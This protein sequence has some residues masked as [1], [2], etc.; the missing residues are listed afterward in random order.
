MTVAKNQESCSKSAEEKI[1]K[2]CV[3]EQNADT[4]IVNVSG[5]LEF[6][7]GKRSEEARWKASLDI[8]GVGLFVET[9]KTEIET[10]TATEAAT[11]TETATSSKEGEE[12][13]ATTRRRNR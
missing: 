1:R 4:E 12:I 13:T 10:A 9:A 7:S 6:I 5:G 11:E 8:A 3:N 2:P